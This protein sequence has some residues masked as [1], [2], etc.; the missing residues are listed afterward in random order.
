MRQIGQAT[1]GRQTLWDLATGAIDASRAKAGSGVRAAIERFQEAMGTDAIDYEREGLLKGASDPAARRG[2]LRE[3]Y[4]AGVPLDDLR[5][6]VRRD[7]LPLVP[8]EAV[9]R[10][11]G[12][13]TVDALAETTELDPAFLRQA[14]AALGLGLPSDTSVFDQSA[15]DAAASLREL[16]EAGLSDAAV[17]EVCRMVGR[18]IATLAEGLREVFGETFLIPGDTE[19]DVGLRYAAAARRLLPVFEPMLRFTLTMHILQLIRSDV[20]SRVE[21]SSGELPGSHEVAV[22]F[23]DLSGFTRLSEQ[24]DPERVG[25]LVRRFDRLVQATMPPEVRHV[26]TIGDAAMLVCPDPGTLVE[27]VGRLVV[28]AGSHGSELPRIHAGITCGRAVTREGDWHGG[29]VNLASR[30]AEATPAGQVFVTKDVRDLTEGRFR[31]VGHMR[32]RGISEPLQLFSLVLGPSS[33]PADDDHGD[34]AD[35]AALR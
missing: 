16:Q 11:D 22:A 13:Y 35:D 26:K 8:L 1:R 32:L 27:S 10:A 3:L 28:A 21:L 5:E 19:R 15:V 20:V 17:E 4:A 31:Y 7:R 30:L 33:P 6:A 14:F 23:A 25:A 2:L 24:L 9:L 34:A 18:R 29:P 12:S